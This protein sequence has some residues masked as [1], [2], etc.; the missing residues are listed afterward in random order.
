MLQVMA[1]SAYSNEDRDFHRDRF[2]VPPGPVARARVLLLDDTWTSGGRLQS[3]AFA[4]KDAGAVAV[5]AVVLGRH[6]NPAFGP[7]AS[8][9]GRLRSAQW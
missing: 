4:L 2:F 7:S 1:S 9:I 8:M 5:A 3:L 6:V